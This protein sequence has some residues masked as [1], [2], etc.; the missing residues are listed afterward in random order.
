MP[1]KRLLKITSLR[2]INVLQVKPASFYQYFKARDIFYKKER[3][4]VKKVTEW[5]PNGHFI[6]PNGTFYSF[7]S[8]FALKNGSKMVANGTFYLHNIRYSVQFFDVEVCNLF[9]RVIPKVK[10]DK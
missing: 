4:P 3:K 1:F 9:N 6:H 2:L 8:H 7:S 10:S 5:Y